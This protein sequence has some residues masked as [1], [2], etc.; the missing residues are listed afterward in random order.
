MPPL[1]IA[2]DTGRVDAILYAI[3]VDAIERAGGWPPFTSSHHMQYYVEIFS[4]DFH[5]RDERD[6]SDA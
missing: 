5:I 6:A 1:L 3:F 4:A 2:I